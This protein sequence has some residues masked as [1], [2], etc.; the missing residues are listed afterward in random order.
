MCEPAPLQQALCGHSSDDHH[1]FIKGDGI[2]WY[3][4]MIL[5][6]WKNGT[7]LKYS[8]GCDSQDNYDVSDGHTMSFGKSP[9]TRLIV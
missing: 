4:M 1:R 3:D 6:D 9:I 8:W 7:V 2:R 5:K